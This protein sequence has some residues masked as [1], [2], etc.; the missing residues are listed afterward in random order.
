MH[1]QRYETFQ[2]CLLLIEKTASFRIL[3]GSVPLIW[4]QPS[5]SLQFRPAIDAS[6][7][8]SDL[9]I[10]SIELHFKRLLN[11]YGRR[12]TVVDLI[13]RFKN[14]GHFHQL[15]KSYEE[16]ISYIQIILGSHKMEPSFCSI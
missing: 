4:S 16:V 10:R 12:I 6:Q 14:Q 3:R 7:L 8:E 13:D 5:V 11:I 15:S 2:S 9:S 1:Q